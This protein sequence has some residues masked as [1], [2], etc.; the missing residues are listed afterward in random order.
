MVGD[1]YS[2]VHHAA[3]ERLCLELNREEEELA[4]K[5]AYKY[6][7]QT[8]ISTGIALTGMRT[9]RPQSA[10]AQLRDGVDLDG[11]DRN[12]HCSNTVENH[13]KLDSIARPWEL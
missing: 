1:E 10:R 12:S 3:D 4:Y 7:P 13:Q 2:D 6:S 8:G 9:A 5:L 11:V